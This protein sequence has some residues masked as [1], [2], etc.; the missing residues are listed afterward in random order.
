MFRTERLG[1]HPIMAGIIHRQ[2]ARLIEIRTGGRSHL[3][4]S[5]KIRFIMKGVDPDQHNENSADDP[6]VIARLRAIA[7]DMSVEL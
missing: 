1:E 3:A 7:K 4:A 5:I 2:I 6:T